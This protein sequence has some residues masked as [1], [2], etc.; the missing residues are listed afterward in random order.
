MYLLEDIRTGSDD[1]TEYL[2]SWLGHYARSHGKD[3]HAGLNEDEQRNAVRELCSHLYENLSNW[4][5]EQRAIASNS[6]TTAIFSIPANGP[7]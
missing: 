1:I 3:S 7:G 4:I 6:I 5:K 2:N